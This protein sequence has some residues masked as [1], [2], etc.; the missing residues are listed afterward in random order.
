MQTKLQVS[1]PGDEYEREADQ[2]A[3]QVM[4]MP[5]SSNGRVAEMKASGSLGRA[6]HASGGAAHADNVPAVVGDVLRSTGEPLDASTRAFMEPRFG[7]NFSDVRVHTNARAA[8]SARSVNALAYT[9]GRNVVFGARQYVPGTTTGQR[10]LAHE[11][12]HVVQQGRDAILPQLQRQPAPVKA[13]AGACTVVDV[14]SELDPGALLPS[15]YFRNGQALFDDKKQSAKDKYKSEM[16]AAK[17][18]NCATKANFSDVA[19]KWDLGNPKLKTW[20]SLSINKDSHTFEINNQLIYARKPCC[21]CF[22]GSLTWSF[23]VDASRIFDKGQKTQRTET[24]K[25]AA[26]LTGTKKAGECAGT[27]C[28]S[29][30][31]TFPITLWLGDD[32]VSINFKGSITLTGKIFEK[33]A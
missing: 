27:E 5:E 28:C 12:T 14:F 7:H 9:V 6:R 11:L 10:L 21:A 23:T 24:G 26:P 8:E 29:I 33:E 17:K 25:T 31:K 3:E 1:T 13:A 32:E 20:W 2:V 15:A 18:G 19:L 16:E 22:S 30:N 4:R